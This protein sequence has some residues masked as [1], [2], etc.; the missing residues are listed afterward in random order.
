MLS[1]APFT[2]IPSHL[3]LNYQVLNHLSTT[4]STCSLSFRYTAVL[5]RFLNALYLAVIVGVPILIS[6]VTAICCGFLVCR[7]KLELYR[8]ARAEN[9][10]LRRAAHELRT[11]LDASVAARASMLTNLPV[12]P[13]AATASFHVTNPGLSQEQLVLFVGVAVNDS[14]AALSDR[15]IPE[16]VE[17]RPG[18]SG[19]RAATARLSMGRAT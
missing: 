8:I 5:P 7:R 3:C 17:L 9:A 2:L 14:G 19:L 12:D 6:A 11:A 16:A 15:S 10:A 18:A 1:G 13:A 4:P